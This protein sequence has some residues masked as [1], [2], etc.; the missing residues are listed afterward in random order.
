SPGAS[1]ARAASPGASPVVNA[2]D[3]RSVAQAY[4]D[5]WNAKDYSGMY[6]LISSA[7]QGNITR[8]KF[9]ARYQGIAEEAGLTAVQATLGDATP[10]VAQFPMRVA[11]QSSL[12]GSIT[13][14]NTLPLRQDGDRWRVAWTPSL[15][16]K[17]LG[18]GLIRFI[19]DT[20]ER[21]RILDAK[22][23]VLAQQGLVTQIG[24]VPGQIKDEPQLLAGLSKALGIPPDVIKSRYAKADPTWFVPIK[25]MPENL[26]PD[27]DNQLK[28]LPG[29]AER[30]VKDRVYPYGSLAAH[31]VGYVG[32]VNADDL[33]TL[34][35]KG[36]TAGDKIGRAGIESWGEQY[37]AG[38]KGGQIT[39]IGTNG[40]VRTV[41]AQRKS[42]PAA[43]IQLTID[44]DLQRALEEALG[45]RPSSGVILDPATGGVLA[46]ASHPTFDPNGF[47][48]GFSDADWA[49][50]NDSKLTPLIN[51]AAQGVYPSGSIFK[52]IPATA[53]VNE[54]GFTAD[55]VIDCPATF[56]VPGQ[57][58]V[59][60]DWT[61]P[62]P[63]GPL[64][65]KNALVRSCDTVF[66]QIAVKLNEK[67]PYLLPNY[68]RA[69]GLGKPTGLEELPEAS[70]LVPDPK[71]KEEVV[72]DGWA[73]G[74]A[75]NF[76]I[77]QGYFLA[78][79]LQMANLYNAIA[80]GGSLLRPFIAAKV[81]TPDG[82]I[83]RATE[84]KE[85]AKLPTQKSLPMI[86]QAMVDITT[87][88]N[89]TSL[90]AFRGSPIVV[91]G[92]TGTAEKPPLADN[93]WFAS[94]APADA[95]KLTVITMVEHGGAGSKVAA[96]VARHVYDVWAGM[97][98]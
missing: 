46:M 57:P 53:A 69:F 16:F 88:P 34:A 36:Y 23:R 10:G 45:D 49:K 93:A 66:Y 24:V 33:K 18:D 59:W 44:I 19:P 7:D 2:R 3:M 54:L 98:H 56:S 37:L 43:D 38:K 77:G 84:R 91:A 96:P 17:D 79:P 86:H 64:S 13:E 12:V 81:T 72:H 8:D 62:D 21:G 60:R 22:G 26:P 32:E 6:D 73:V 85:I 9:V 39:V 27:L 4:V 76:S 1:P 11:M 51:R 90:D 47:I 58:N 89:G 71:W 87:A 61:Y 65:L 74:D 50:L 82:K 80:N 14:D 94:F 15:I 67:D 52:V 55:T 42:E 31:I 35:A 40:A 95:P 25:T 63:Q 70:G 48:L 78:T 41:I 92:K 5:R 75:I 29:V 68:A 28:A 20:P 30:K 97:Q 83:V